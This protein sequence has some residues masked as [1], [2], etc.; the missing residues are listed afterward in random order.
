MD[1]PPSASKSSVGHAEAAAGTTAILEVVTTLRARTIAP[2][3]HLRT[4]NAHLS[5]AL[6]S[7]RVCTGNGDSGCIF[8]M[9]RGG[10]G[11]AACGAAGVSAFAFMGTNVHVVLSGD[12]DWSTSAPSS[13]PSREKTTLPWRRERSW[14][15][16]GPD[17][18]VLALARVAATRVSR[19]A[20]RMASSPAE[21]RS[22]HW[23]PYDRVRVVNA[24]P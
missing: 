10:G 22:I 4:L 11:A 20:A 9:P 5:A 19:L 7:H 24:D 21:V 2:L 13:A 6:E 23:F 17:G 15:L 16:D 18:G 3:K 8:I 1:P 14:R 12:D